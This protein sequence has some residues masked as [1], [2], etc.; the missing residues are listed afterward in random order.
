MRTFELRQAP[1]LEHWSLTQDIELVELAIG[2]LRVQHA[3]VEST[4]VTPESPYLQ[5]VSVELVGLFAGA[6]EAELVARLGRGRV[7]S[8][9]WLV[10][11]E[12]VLD[13]PHSQ[14]RYKGQALDGEHMNAH[15]VVL[16]VPNNLKRA[17]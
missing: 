14:V 7:Q 2:I 12:L 5:I 6:G 8:G 16:S 1:L 3:V 17:K 10:V 4:V 9:H 11:F 15:I 13:G